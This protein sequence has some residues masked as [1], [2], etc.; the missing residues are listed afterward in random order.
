MRTREEIEAALAQARVDREAA[1]ADRAKAGSTWRKQDD[2]D[3]TYDKVRSSWVQAD[4]DW[5]EANAR[6]EK[7]T[8]DL[9]ELD[10]AANLTEQRAQLE[11]AVAGARVERD[12]ADAALAA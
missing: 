3:L 12:K 9:A 11:A 5:N 7:L 1:A 10:R 8:A 4:A 6:I 2:A